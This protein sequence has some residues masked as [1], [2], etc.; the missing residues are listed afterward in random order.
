[1]V[2]LLMELKFQTVLDVVGM[3]L[4][5]PDPIIYGCGFLYMCEHKSMEWNAH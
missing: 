4:D 3:F 5:V 1:M 2:G